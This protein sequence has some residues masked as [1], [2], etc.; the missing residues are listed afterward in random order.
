[1]ALTPEEQAELEQ[2]ES[3]VAAETAPQGEI[4]ETP[5]TSE[6][7]L[8]S[9]LIKGANQIAGAVPG[10]ALGAAAG[11]PAGA[12]VGAAGGGALGNTLANVQ[13]QGVDN[14]ADYLRGKQPTGLQDIPAS[15][16]P[17]GALGGL[18]N[19]FFDAAAPV[20]KGLFGKASAKLTPYGTA[21][22]KTRFGKIATDDAAKTATEDYMGALAHEAETPLE[23]MPRVPKQVT[24][25]S[26]S[27]QPVMSEF[28]SAERVGVT[29][30]LAEAQNELGYLNDVANPQQL[31]QKAERDLGYRAVAKPDG[32]VVFQDA[33]VQGKLSKAIDDGMKD[34]SAEEVSKITTDQLKPLDFSAISESYSEALGKYLDSQEGV[35]SQEAIDKI[36]QAGADRI[37]QLYETLGS[38][39]SLLKVHNIR[40]NMDRE[41]SNAFLKNPY[42]LTSEDYTNRAVANA[43]RSVEKG[44][45]E[46]VGGE[47]AKKLLT[48]QRTYQVVS[49]L[50]DDFWK[51]T[52]RAQ[53]G[54]L[55][56]TAKNPLNKAGL[57]NSF[58]EWLKGKLGLTLPSQ[59][60]Q[61]FAESQAL[62]KAA[63]NNVTAPVNM[64]DIGYAEK[65]KS[66]LQG[67]PGMAAQGAINTTGATLTSAPTKAFTVGSMS[68]WGPLALNDGPVQAQQLPPALP[69]NAQA[70]RDNALLIEQQ[71]KDP[72]QAMDFQKLM[73]GGSDE[74]IEQFMSHSFQL[75][76]QLET[77][78]E[79]APL[80]SQF[81]KAVTDPMVKY[82]EDQKLSWQA[83]TYQ[84][85]P[86]EVFRARMNLHVDKVP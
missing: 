25:L 80:K 68:S 28:N 13:L 82:Q 71:L 34:L 19:L 11:G 74:D 50:Y 17:E 51:A 77:L 37:Q 79:A 9:T 3:E 61:L 53:K 26:Q 69:R 38:N 64:N 16:I 63:G 8:M 47:K 30:R 75:D 32:S 67:L 41:V 70:I 62:S 7:P 49:D 22:G 35:L 83:L 36:S 27:L 10:A 23:A 20:V 54:E 21:M 55:G 44:R 48:D 33:R 85:S 24:K 59:T 52:V 18:T 5:F 65:L 12:V 6:H 86:Q 76:P 4:R 42:E 29:R 1:M 45:I 31:V 73:Q 66:G 78:F 43:L 46:E 14:V 60:E 81:G 58:N 15:A 84:K 56:N 2:L 39:P 57:V 72:E 40:V